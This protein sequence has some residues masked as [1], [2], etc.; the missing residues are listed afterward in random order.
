MREPVVIENPSTYGIDFSQIGGIT[1][2]G[3]MQSTMTMTPD[4]TL[5]FL[6]LL[7]YALVTLRVSIWATKRREML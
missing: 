6:V 2:G 1:P 7:L 3:G 5:G 4:P